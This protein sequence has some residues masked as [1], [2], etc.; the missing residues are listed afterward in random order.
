M[1]LDALLFVYACTWIVANGCAV[2]HLR[3]LFT[4]AKLFLRKY[5]LNEI[6]LLES[7]W[8]FCP[9]PNASRRKSSKITFK[10][11]YWLGENWQHVYLELQRKIRLPVNVYVSRVRVVLSR[12][13]VCSYCQRFFATFDSLYNFLIATNITLDDIPT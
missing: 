13:R 5:L 7:L 12:S 9:R 8:Y 4:C 1:K 3:P 2:H 6:A 10:F 11:E